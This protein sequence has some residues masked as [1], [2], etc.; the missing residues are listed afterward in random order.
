VNVIIDIDRDTSITLE[1]DQAQL[2][3]TISRFCDHEVAS[4]STADARVLAME[5]V[6]WADGRES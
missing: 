1:P 5:L 3:L 2:H 4:L 6:S